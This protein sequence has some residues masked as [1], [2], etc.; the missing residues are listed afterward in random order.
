MIL[1]LEDMIVASG[2][3]NDIKKGLLEYLFVS[4]PSV[5]YAKYCYKVFSWVDLIEECQPGT[6]SAY[7]YKVDHNGTTAMWT[8]SN[9]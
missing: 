5:E 7:E 3:F 2:G 9:K 8:L 6:V 4:N 1:R